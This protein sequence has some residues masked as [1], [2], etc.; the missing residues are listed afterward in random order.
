MELICRGIDEPNSKSGYWLLCR[1]VSWQPWD[2]LQFPTHGTDSLRKA[3]N[4]NFLWVRTN[5]AVKQKCYSG[6]V[7]M[8]RKQRIRRLSTSKLPSLWR[9][10]NRKTLLVAV[11]FL[12]AMFA[13]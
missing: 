4:G 1:L 6:S 9:W 7:R 2:P 8:T 13:L 3:A 10:Q 5:T 11:I 12:A